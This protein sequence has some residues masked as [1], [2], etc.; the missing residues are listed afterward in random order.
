MPQFIVVAGPNGAGKSTFSAHFSRPGALIFDP[1][2]QKYKIEKQYQD[3]SFEAV[4]SELTRKYYTFEARAL[5]SHLHFTVETNLRNDFL[6]ERADFFHEQG[7]ETRMI[8]MLL[9]DVATSMDRVNLRV[10]QKGHPID[11]DSIKTNFAKG[12]ENLALIAPRF[13]QLMILSADNSGLEKTQPQ[14]LLTVKNGAIIQ[15]SEKI[16]LWC[17]DTINN[18]GQIVGSH[19]ST[20]GRNRD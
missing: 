18:I 19:V 10:K 1:D 14:L 4:E 7:Y 8:Y 15:K 13:D 16:P 9:P 17:L 6:A 20:R 11:V 2:K 5:G 3:I 12:L